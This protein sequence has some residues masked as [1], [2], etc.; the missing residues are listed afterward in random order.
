M[1]PQSRGPTPTA[2]AN[3]SAGHRSSSWRPRA[4]HAAAKFLAARKKNADKMSLLFWERRFDGTYIATV[5]GAQCACSRVL[6]VEVTFDP[7]LAHF[8]NA[9]RVAIF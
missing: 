2:A 9:L 5:G 1:P 3:A 7:T 8:G 6:G 4:I